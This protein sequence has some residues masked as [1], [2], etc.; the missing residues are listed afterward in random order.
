MIHIIKLQKI[1]TVNENWAITNAQDTGK[2]F[3]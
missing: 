3:I 1:Q 2:K